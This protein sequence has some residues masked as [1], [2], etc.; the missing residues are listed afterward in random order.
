MYNIALIGA[1]SL[2]RRHIEGLL[3]L[4]Q[5]NSIWVVDPSL[6]SLDEARRLPSASMLDRVMFDTSIGSLPETLHYVVVATSA[7]VRL[8]VMKALLKGRMVQSMLLEKVLFQRRADYSAAAALVTQKG[9]RTWV[10]TARR[11]MDTHQSIRHFFE[12]ET[13]TYFDVRGGE[14]GLGCNGIHFSTSC[15]SSLD[16]RR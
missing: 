16:R 11:A 1:G 15:R 3:K 7:N 14:W 4:P 9:V 5:E 13:I 10:N 2:G 6:A 8:E 12:G